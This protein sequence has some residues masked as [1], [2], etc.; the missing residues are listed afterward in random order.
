[1]AGL[2]CRNDCLELRHDKEKTM[3]PFQ[4]P[5][6]LRLGA[7]GAVAALALTA[8]WLILNA[9]Q[10]SS[11][12]HGKHQHAAKA[13]DAGK[14]LAARLQDL[15]AKVAKLEAALK[16][17][18]TSIAPHAGAA[19]DPA[20]GMGGKKKMGMSGMGMMGGM[21]M[22]GMMGGMAGMGGKKDGMPGMGMMDMDM[23]EMMGMMGMGGMG[24]QG[25]Q[26][27]KGKMRMTAALPGFPGASHLYHIGA[28]G[29]FLDHPEHIKLTAK[30][31]TGLGRVK[32]KALL[33]KAT[34]Q[35]KVEEAEQELW[36]L[37]GADRP[38]AAK[39][40]AKVRE[41]ERLRGDQRLA[42][43]RAVGEAAQ[44]LT[45]EQRQALLG[46]AADK[47]GKPD[48]HAGH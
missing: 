35:R 39:V 11:P 40:E 20:M 9:A 21:D 43:I 13:A 8:G 47:G 18:Q 30:Q 4:R 15:Q 23:M 34:A 29:F 10:S 16:H 5:T 25:M 22:G 12:N 27:M 36:A 33:D 46:A 42:F 14:D 31:Q 26:G 24:Q 37:T 44:I 7:V 17:S 3:W 2:K 41:I 45:D 28:T 19:G 48:P 1:M 6:A 32:E 38:H